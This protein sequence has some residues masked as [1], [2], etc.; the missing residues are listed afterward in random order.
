M[1]DFDYRLMIGAAGLWLTDEFIQVQGSGDRTSRG[2]TFG[3]RQCAVW[4]GLGL[5]RQTGAAFN[6]TV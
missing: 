4:R 6:Y 2:E 3:G 1:V 5:G